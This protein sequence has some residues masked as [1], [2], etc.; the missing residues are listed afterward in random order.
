[1]LNFDSNAQSKITI[2]KN[3]FPDGF[4]DLGE[5]V[6]RNGKKYQTFRF[7]KNNILVKTVTGRRA[8]VVS[9]NGALAYSGNMTI[10]ISFSE[11]NDSW[12][13][14]VVR[15]ATWNGEPLKLVGLRK[16]C[17]YDTTTF[18]AA[19]K[20]AD[21]WTHP[22]WTS[23]KDYNH[24]CYHDKFIFSYNI[25]QS[26]LDALKKGLATSIRSEK[27]KLANDDGYKVRI[28]NEINKFQKTIQIKTIGIINML[29]EELA[30]FAPDAYEYGYRFC[31]RNNEMEINK[32]EFKN[33]EQYYKKEIELRVYKPEADG[34][35]N[36]YFSSS[37]L[38]TKIYFEHNSTGSIKVTFDDL[39]T[40]NND[41]AYQMQGFT[42]HNQCLTMMLNNRPTVS[43]TEDSNA[44][45]RHSYMKIANHLFKLAKQMNDDEIKFMGDLNENLV[46]LTVSGS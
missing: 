38:R 1:M 33:P 14:C 45:F 12:D 17:G 35:F 43:K 31:T 32:Y 9:D 20:E 10:D 4:E 19:K 26:I 25:N 30:E 34:S 46:N 29:N 5:C 7:T 39:C 16:I 2:M 23:Q 3:N 15:G 24:F 8:R 28:E 37:G 44:E 6:S 22:H 40:N 21:N 41:Y 36:Q 11:N 13:F 42:I 27:K 18:Y